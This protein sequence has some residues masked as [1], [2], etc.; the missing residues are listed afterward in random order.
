[1]QTN[2]LIADLFKY[3]TGYLIKHLTEIDKSR[4]FIRPNYN[5]NPIIWIFGH[6]IVSR[7]G[8]V[9]ILGEDS[10]TDNMVCFFSSG[11]VPLNDPSEYPH[12]DELM[13]KFRNLNAQLVRIIIEGGESL[14]VKQAWGEHDTLGKHLISGY[15]HE[16]YHI[17]QISYLFKF[18]SNPLSRTTRFNYKTKR[19]NSTSKILLDSLKSVLTV[20]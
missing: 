9:E 17:G 10:Q 14:L 7:G 15:I 13:S 5:L 12:I 11:T 3:N 1:M 20:K 8:L 18:T 4:L 19:K 6:I 2:K 16:S